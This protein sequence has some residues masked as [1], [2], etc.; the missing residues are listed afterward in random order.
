MIRLLLV[1]SL[2]SS[3]YF[4]GAQIVNVE[5]RRGTFTDTIGWFESLELGFNLI[6]NNDRIVNIKGSFYLEVLQKKRVFLSITKF[7]FIRAG[8]QNFVDQG[9]QHL[10]FTRIISNRLRFETFGQIQY[11]EQ[12]LVRLRALA[13]AGP[14]LRIHKDKKS[15]A[16]YG[17]AYMYEYEEKSNLQ[18]G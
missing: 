12:I 11:N 6:Q 5:D 4:L 17:I 13:G 14:R 18:V 9:F 10:R 15:K 2:T 16:Y 7:E 8:D 3:T 1:L